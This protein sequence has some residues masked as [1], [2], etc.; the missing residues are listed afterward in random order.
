MTSQQTGA[1]GREYLLDIIGREAFEDYEDQSVFQALPTDTQRERLDAV[2]YA[3]GLVFARFAQVAGYRDL[4]NLEAVRRPGGNRPQGLVSADQVD[5]SWDLW[6][7]RIGGNGNLSGESSRTSR[8]FSGNVSASRVSPTWK[9][10][11]RVFLNYNFQKNKFPDR[12]K[13]VDERTDWNFNSTDVYSLAQF[14]SLGFTTRVGR[15]VRENTEFSAEISPAIEY[16]LFPYEEATR[17]SVTAFYEIGPAYFNYIEVTQD[18]LLEETRFQQALSLQVSQRQTWG[19]ASLTV[20]GSHYLHDFDRNNLEVSG[21]I[22]FRITRGL[23]VNFGGS[24]TLV[25]DQLYL[26]FEQLTD[27]ELLTGVRSAFTD[28]E[29]FVFFGLSFQ[30]GSIFN[31]VVN[32]RFSGAGGG[33][34]NFGGGGGGGRGGGRGGGGGNRF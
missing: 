5:D 13:F 27:D 4:V 9:Q 14:W 15:S 3:L 19:D 16:S 17:R 18:E 6:V 26:P 31:N 23:D 28:K 32:N 34:G 33:F 7:F 8:R 1:N 12:P 10:N 20:R 24:Y 30:F 25:A 21:N 29:Y 11:Y 2:T 22:S